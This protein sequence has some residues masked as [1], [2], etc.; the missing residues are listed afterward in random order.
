RAGTRPAEFVEFVRATRVEDPQAA[1]IRVMTIHQAKG[2]QFDIVV[3]PELEGRLK[4]TTPK[5][6]V[7]RPQP[8]DPIE[9]V[10]R[11]VN[12]A[13]WPLLPKAYQDLFEIWPREAVNE[14]LCLL[15]VALT[16][17]VHALHLVVP[18]TADNE[19]TFP[20]TFAG[21]L[22]GALAA[23]RKLEPQTVAYE[24]GQRD[25][26]RLPTSGEVSEASEVSGAVDVAAAEPEVVEVR[27]AP[28]RATPR[29]P[30]RLSPSS[31]EGAGK[32]RLARR[33]NPGGD[34]Y[35]LRGTLWHA[36]FEQ[37]EWLGEASSTPIDDDRLRAIALAV[38]P[39]LEI[40]GEIGEF[41][42]VVGQAELRRLLSRAAY[43][44]P[45][46]LG[47]AAKGCTPRVLRERRFA[48]REKEGLLSGTID[49]LVLLER[50]GAVQAADVIDFKTDVLSGP[51]D[52]E[53]RVKFY[54][55][56]LNAYR[57]AVG[58]LYRLAP[59]QVAGRLVFVAKAEVRAIS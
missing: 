16:R 1:R 23:G 13:F 25:W 36:W 38:G 11:H 27:L 55:P 39:G 59:T 15:Y 41:R 52:L 35:F 56:Q 17:A 40:D 37:I 21:V 10:C 2:L 31:L 28:Q 7:G 44:D 48:I 24:H 8:V 9:R 53:N 33:L 20:Q 30:A 42:R 54:Q 50:H 12:K 49:R 34:A 6:A 26:F 22:R 43:A 51:A 14:S 3:L 46:Q 45:S 4:G 19:R 58:R 5:L 57:H 18:P 47:L 32:V 29:E